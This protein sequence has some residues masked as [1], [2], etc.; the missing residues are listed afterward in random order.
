MSTKHAFDFKPVKSQAL[1]EIAYHPESLTLAVR[2]KPGGPV[3]R[4]RD[5]TPKKWADMQA[6]DSL[7][8]FFATRV[9]NHHPH[10]G[11]DA[12]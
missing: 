8:S 6:A 12:E 9:R 4:Y 7:G 10:I 3:H 2:F 5:V 11:P 1:A